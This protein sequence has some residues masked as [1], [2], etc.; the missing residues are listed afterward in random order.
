M[1]DR[2]T[3]ANSVFILKTLNEYFRELP[4]MAVILTDDATN[5]SEKNVSIFLWK[6]ENLENISLERDMLVL[7]DFCMFDV[8]LSRSVL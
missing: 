4:R 3:K 1:Q 2:T 6:R 5:Y 7:L 8:F